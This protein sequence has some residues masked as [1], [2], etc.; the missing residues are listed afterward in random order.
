MWTE[1]SQEAQSMNGKHEW[2]WGAEDRDG[3]SGGDTQIICTADF[4]SPS[5]KQPQFHPFLE[6]PAPAGT[7]SKHAPL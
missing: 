7:L 4:R 6:K 3:R 1:S 5:G 2:E